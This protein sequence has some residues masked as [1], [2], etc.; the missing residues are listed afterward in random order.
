M[1]LENVDL[2][3]GPAKVTIPALYLQP[4]VLT[5]QV[6]AVKGA[7]A[8]NCAGHSAQSLSLISLLCLVERVGA[9]FW[10]T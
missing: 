3:L 1:E 7:L 6:C 8:Q 10:F 2:V 9:D 4:G 5:A